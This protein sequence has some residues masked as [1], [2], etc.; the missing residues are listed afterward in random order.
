MSEK[1]Y[2]TTAIDYPSGNPHMGHAYEKL[3]TDVIA[4]WKTLEGKD[5]FFLTGTDEHGQKIQKAAEKAK[6][7]PEKFVD[8]QA[9]KFEELCKAWNI[10]NND[11]IRTTEKRHE[12]VVLQIFDKINQKKLIYLDKYVGLYCSDCEAFYQKK[13]LQNGLCPIHKTKPE[14]IEEDSY[15]FK[16]SE[17]KEPLLKYLEKNESIL[18]KKKQK[19]IVNRVKKE[20]KDLSIS[21]TS[22]DWGIKLPINQKHVLYVWLDA[23][24][25]YI[26]GIDYPDKKFEKF[27]PADAHVIGKDILWFHSV[28]W[29]AILMAADIEPAKTVLVHGFINTDSGEKMSKSKGNVIDP[30]A[31]VKK[32]ELDSIRYFLVRE[33]PFGED[34]FFSEKALKERNNNEL[35]NELG[36]LLN[37]TIS[38]IE[39]YSDGKIPKGK[40]DEQ[41]KKALKLDQIRNHM[42]KFELHLAL[43]QIMGFVKECNKFI[44]DKKP[45]ENEQNRENVLYSLADSLRIISILLWPFIP[46]SSKEIQKQLGVEGKSLQECRF[47]LTQEAKTSKGNVLFQKLD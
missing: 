4:R 40:T 13:D 32:Y 37:R 45:W 1:F 9:K 47:D 22:F 17:F 28:I 24:T 20:L 21:R 33:I 2:I 29:P 34:G 42:N 11:F 7:K 36:N 31:L 39:R 10:S 41:L 12:K 3:V 19:E 14:E 26:S 25:N 18:P 6:L 46:A 16:L 8:V 44:N 38:M 5:T 27:W 23:L 35:A 15:F 30:F 43:G